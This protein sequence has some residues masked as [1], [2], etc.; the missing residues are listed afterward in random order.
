MV[1]DMILLYFSISLDK[2]SD[3]LEKFSHID[4]S[5]KGHITL[6]YI[7]VSV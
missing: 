6:S 5:G 4:L 3:M 1:K 2:L 7:S